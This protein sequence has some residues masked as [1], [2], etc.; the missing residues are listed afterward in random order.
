MEYYSIQSISGSKKNLLWTAKE[1]SL[2]RPY[3]AC[4]TPN[5]G[6]VK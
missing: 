2:T 5:K 4:F 6:I 3:F 1:A